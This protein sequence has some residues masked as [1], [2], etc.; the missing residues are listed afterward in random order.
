[1]CQV[2]RLS[3][4]VQRGWSESVETKQSPCTQRGFFAR[5]RC[6]LLIRPGCLLLSLAIVCPANNRYP[7]S[8]QL[9][10]IM[11]Y[12]AF[13]ARGGPINFSSSYKIRHTSDHKHFELATKMA[14]AMKSVDV[15]GAEFSLCHGARNEIHVGRKSFWVLF[16]FLAVVFWQIAVRSMRETRAQTSANVH[17]DDIGEG[18]VFTEQ[19]F[20]S[21]VDATFEHQAFGLQRLEGESEERVR[22]RRDASSLVEKKLSATNG[23]VRR[24]G[25][26]VPLTYKRSPDV[27]INTAATPIVTRRMGTRS[28]PGSSSRATP[29]PSRCT[30]VRKRVWITKG[31]CDPV[32]V[33][34]AA[35]Q[36]ECQSTVDT[37]G[38]FPYVQRHC[39]SCQPVREDMREVRV[40]QLCGT[41]KKLHLVRVTLPSARSCRCASCDTAERL[42]LPSRRLL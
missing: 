6:D 29:P 11:Q 5:T 38:T 4:T 40:L 39:R 3:C 21:G 28:G 27:L 17:L 10:N 26:Q 13:Y 9:R 19:L 36:G 12:R 14:N 18:G 35:C 2:N 30:P 41:R 15:D 25:V 20:N 16:A 31:K 23:E 24:K 1:M 7:S 8:I 42:P 22:L 33:E 37:K 32:Y 34:V